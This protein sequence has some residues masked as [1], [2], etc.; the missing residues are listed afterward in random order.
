[1]WESLGLN[2]ELG[3]LSASDS[4]MSGKAIQQQPHQ[5]MKRVVVIVATIACVACFG[6]GMHTSRS[7]SSAK[8]HARNALEVLEFAHSG[9]VT[10]A[11]RWNSFCFDVQDGEAKNGSNLQ[12]W[13]CEKGEQHENRR[14]IHGAKGTVR[15]AAHPDF[16]WDVTHGSTDNQANIQLWKC[17]AGG[18]NAN[19]QFIL[20]APGS[21]G[22]IR[23]ASHPSK[24]FDISG[25]RR[26]NGNNV[27]TW[28][29]D[30]GR[31][32]PNQHFEISD[33]IPFEVAKSTEDEGKTT[34][35]IRW[36]KFCFD[37]TDGNADNG[38][39]IQIW[40]C[41]QNGQND[42]KRFTYGN[43]T[44]TVRWAAH[45]DFCLDV[46]NGSTDN[47]AN[48]Q[49]WKCGAGGENANQ[50]FILP[51]PGS[52]GRI[53][54]ASHPSKCFDVAGGKQHNGNNIETWDC[55]DSKQ[56]PNQMYNISD[57]LATM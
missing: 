3:E 5:W 18:E 43:G 37:V 20:P 33:G 34:G 32:N 40:E 7:L 13:G 45:P 24:C 14:F 57:G 52:R 51:A 35:T 28:D 38:S 4:M 17:G 53:R 42:N 55:D 16:C 2:M 23:W 19:Q 26:Q 22:R 25:G 44:S 29:C 47:Q 10:G 49:L 30:D 54:W 27:E 48:I 6:M 50:Q 36:N 1:M 41:D 39:N 46:T 11:I 15:W 8:L 12:I 31:E 21:R 9:E 56:N